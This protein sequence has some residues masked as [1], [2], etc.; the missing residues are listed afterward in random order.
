MEWTTREID[1]RGAETKKVDLTNLL[2][3]DFRQKG[4][5]DDVRRFSPGETY[6]LGLIVNALAE[7]SMETME[8]VLPARG[9]KRASPKSKVQSAK[10]KGW[11]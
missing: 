4:S 11:S 7:W 9:E 6:A 3:A 5:D 1:E 2:E 8:W 10:A